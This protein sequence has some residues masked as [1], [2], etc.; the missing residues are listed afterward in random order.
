[1]KWLVTAL[2]LVPVSLGVA[3]AKQTR[4]RRQ[5]KVIIETGRPTSPFDCDT[6]K[7]REWY[8]SVERCREDLCRGRNESSAYIDGPDGRLRHN[9][10]DHRLGE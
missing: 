5:V 1:M 9:P 6:A 10:C 3:Q 8:G 4:P 7:A 2:I